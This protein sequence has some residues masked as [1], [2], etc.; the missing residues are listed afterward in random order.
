MLGFEGIDGGTPV[1]FLAIERFR[2][3]GTG[4][5]RWLGGVASEW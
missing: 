1:S 3:G 2:E 5:E 4:G